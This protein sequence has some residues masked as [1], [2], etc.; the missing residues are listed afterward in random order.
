M[1]ENKVIQRAK[2][3]SFY[4]VVDDFIDT[5]FPI[6][7]KS[8]NILFSF[9]SPSRWRDKVTPIDV[10]TFKFPQPTRDIF[11]VDFHIEISR[12]VWDACDKKARFRIIW[13]GLRE[14]GVELDENNGIR[15]DASG[16]VILSLNKPDIEVNFFS[17]ECTKFGANGTLISVSKTLAYMVE[18]SNAK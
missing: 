10:K 2:S 3:P 13:R 17:D 12:D 11:G 15:Q 6:L 9:V 7:R 4:K 14:L 5:D 1:F 18:K 8:V 16:R